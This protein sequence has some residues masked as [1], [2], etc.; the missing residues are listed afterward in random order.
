MDE[1]MEIARLHPGDRVTSSH[2]TRALQK[3]RRHFQ[4]EDRLEAQVTLTQREYH[5][6]SNTLDYTFAISRGPAVE[7][8]VEGVKLRRRVIKK[9]FRSM[10]KTPLMMT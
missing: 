2:L 10:R 3:L 8:R 4:R 1:V 5:H 9:L 6:E 7:V